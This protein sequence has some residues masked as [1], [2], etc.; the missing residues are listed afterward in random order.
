MVH[1]IND[2][3]VSRY[4]RQRI[5]SRGGSRPLKTIQ[6]ATVYG[7]DL[8]DNTSYTETDHTSDLLGGRW[9][10]CPYSA[11]TSDQPVHVAESE[12]NGIV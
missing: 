7:I 8:S 3:F 6:T 5:L 9:I 11:G 10:R 2:A 1:N 12:P 4:L